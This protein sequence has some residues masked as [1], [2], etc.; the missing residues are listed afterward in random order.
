[1]RSQTA[2]HPAA[3]IAGHKRAGRAHDPGL[4]EET[5]QYLRDS[6]A[7]RQRLTPRSSSTSRCSRS[8]PIA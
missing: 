8:T 1:M 6:T 3:V 2:L 5:R 7:S 4:I